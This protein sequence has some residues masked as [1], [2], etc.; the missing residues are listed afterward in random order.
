MNFSVNYTDP[1]GQEGEYPQQTITD[2]TGSHDAEC[3][4]ALGLP[5]KWCICQP[6]KIEKI[7]K[8]GGK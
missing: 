6:R 2:A 3:P 1:K 8:S 7:L 4:I 5:N